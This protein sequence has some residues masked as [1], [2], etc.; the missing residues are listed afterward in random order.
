MAAMNRTT[1]CLPALSG[2]R[3]GKLLRIRTASGA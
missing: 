1:H 3:A 2:R